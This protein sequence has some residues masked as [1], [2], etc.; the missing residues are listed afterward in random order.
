MAFLFSQEGGAVVS[1]LVAPRKREGR[2]EE[3]IM[4]VVVV[5]VEEV[6]GGSRACYPA[7]DGPMAAGGPRRGEISKG[8]ISI[9]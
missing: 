4:V 5:V 3:P 2:R 1:V 8:E 9:L 7:M 6:K